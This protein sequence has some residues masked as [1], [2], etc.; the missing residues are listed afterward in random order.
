M[1]QPS[2]NRFA[3]VI[4]AGLAA[5][6]LTVGLV[7]CSSGTG[8]A[9]CVA[10]FKSADPRALPA[11]HVSP[12]DDAVRACS[13]VAQWRSAW[14]AVPAAHEGRTDEMGFLQSRCA[15]AELASTALCLEVAAGP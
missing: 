7:A 6:V 5:V 13:T 10:A 15:L 12:L 1:T 8:D 11:N 14:L 2:G 3:R 4:T 9:R